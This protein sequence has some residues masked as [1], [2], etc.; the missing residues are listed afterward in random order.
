MRAQAL[1]EF[2]GKFT[3]HAGVKCLAALGLQGGDQDYS[4]FPAMIARDDVEQPGL[5]SVYRLPDS[6]FRLRLDE[7]WIGFAGSA[8]CLTLNSEVADAATLRLAGEPLGQG[9]EVQVGDIWKPVVFYPQTAQA[10]LTTNRGNTAASRFEPVIVTPSLAAL[11]ASGQGRG[12][13]LTDVVLDGASAVGVDFTGARFSG[14]SLQGADLSKCLLG[15]ADLRGTRLNGVLFDG[16]LLDRAN[17]SGATLG[18]PGWGAPR[19]AREIDLS[20]CR[21]RGAILGSPSARLDCTQANLGAG[22]FSQADLSGLQLTGARLT[23]AR[24]EGC[25]LEG[26]MLDGA[27]LRNVFALRANLRKCSLKNILG[28]NANFTAA[29]FSAAD[30]SQAHLDAKVHQAGSEPWRPAVL[31]RA[32]CIGTRASGAHLAG[33]DLRGVQW[34]GAGATLDHADLEGAVLSGSLLVSLDLSQAFLNGADLSDSVLVNARIAGCTVLADGSARSLSLEGAQIQGVDFSGSVL[35]G[36]LLVGAGVALEQGVPLFSL[37]LSVW[38]EL[39]CEG[40]A[41]LAPL[42]AQ[43]GYPLGAAPTL[44]LD[45]QWR[46]DNAGDLDPSHPRA[47]SVRWIRGQLEVFDASGALGHLFSLSD[48]ASFSLDGQHPDG[49]LIS[50]FE[51]AGYGLC[52]GA[53]ID[54]ADDPRLRPA[55]DAGILGAFGYASFRLARREQGVQVFGM[56]PLLMRDWPVY[57]VGVAFKATANLAAAMSPD[58]LGPA[59]YPRR[60]LNADGLDAEGF[61]TA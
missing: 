51:R 20:H 11:V 27:D 34:C 32:I 15:D 42:F 28:S 24:L 35:G 54:Q 17:L 23:D 1:G 39:G 53:S 43:A 29:D 18:A 59:G 49:S 40:I 44:D 6:S 5:V 30:L 38:E 56:A 19:S 61:F 16:A 58:S 2:M 22:D 60:W 13:D 4:W 8:G 3:F 55:A 12:V 10:I 33:A 45:R 21:A 52:A 37:P 50:A 48:W 47:Y 36:A 7:R 46:I 26:A 25:C 14:A 41:G 9:W 31:H 57:S